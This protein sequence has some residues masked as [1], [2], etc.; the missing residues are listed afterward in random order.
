MMKPLFIA[1]FLFATVA[2]TV[3]VAGEG[4]DASAVVVKIPTMLSWGG[5]APTSGDATVTLWN[6][7][8]FSAGVAPMP[9][10][11]L[12][13][14]TGMQMGGFLAWQAGDY[15]VDAMLAP[16]LG[17]AVV[18][19]LGA[20]MGSQPGAPGTSYGLHVG[21]AWVGE[22]FTVNPASG[23]GLAEVA[24]PTSDVNLTFTI[25]HALTPS[26][27]LTG[28]AEARRSVGMSLDGVANQNRFLFGAGV[29]YRF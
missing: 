7:G 8:G 2:A 16:T 24:A 23:L 22:H 20:V 13:S 1:S 5:A 12:A 25:N 6:G 10:R 27:S 19:G 21:A 18:A 29:G 17:G 3:A 4:G 28:T 26:L 14:G 15:R 11:P 9:G